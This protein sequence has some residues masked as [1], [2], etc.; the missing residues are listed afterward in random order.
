MSAAPH[1]PV[2]YEEYLAAER[3]AGRKREYLR[4]LVWA[5]AARSWPSR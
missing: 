1:S 4:G 2:R 5:M 3:S